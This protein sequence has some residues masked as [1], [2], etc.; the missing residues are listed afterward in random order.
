MDFE[1]ITLQF[2]RELNQIN[3]EVPRKWGRRLERRRRQ[4]RPEAQ[5]DVSLAMRRGWRLT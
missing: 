1:T 3:S 5:L 4:I 2:R